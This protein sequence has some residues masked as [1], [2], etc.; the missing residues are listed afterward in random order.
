MIFANSIAICN[1][2]GQKWEYD[3]ERKG[4]KISCSIDRI[5]VWYT[6]WWIETNRSGTVRL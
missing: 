6:C 1:E 2:A 5:Y 3:M 4:S